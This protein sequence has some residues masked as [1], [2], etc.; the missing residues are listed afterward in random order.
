METVDYRQRFEKCKAA[1]EKAVDA[2]IVGTLGT[3]VKG[4]AVPLENMEDFDDHLVG[5]ATHYDALPPNDLAALRATR[6]YLHTS[7]TIEIHSLLRRFE[8]SCGGN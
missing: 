6:R 7:K 4:L 5:L 8:V 1:I 3:F 2:A